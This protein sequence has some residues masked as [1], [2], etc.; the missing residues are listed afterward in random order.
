MIWEVEKLK[1]QLQHEKELRIAKEEMLQQK[2][3]EIQAL[4]QILS[5]FQKA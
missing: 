4:R 3:D 2:N 5:I 1:L